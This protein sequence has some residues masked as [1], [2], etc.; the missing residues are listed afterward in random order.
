MVQRN[1]TLDHEFICITENP[2]NL[3]PGIK[4]MDLELKAGIE[5]WWYKPMI[6]NPHL[7]LQGTILFLDLDMIIF[8]NM[9][10]LFSY[11]QGEFC[12]IRDF[13]RHII[14]NYDKFNSSIMRFET[15]Q[16]SQVYHK[17]M[18]DMQG[19][20]RRFQGDQDWTRHAIQ[21]DYNYWPDEWIQ[22]YKWEM[23]GKPRMT[24]GPRG[25]RD[26][27]SQGEPDILPET[28]IAVFHGDPN[29]HYCKDEWVQ[30]NWC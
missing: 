25:T 7:G 19:I 6:F 11:K 10:K 23:R 28:F 12:I 15:G 2:T 4:I 16:H 22:S 5:G 20:S 30:K 9:D 18:E 13:N 14:P 3:D 24:S 27:E 26:F 8:G 1:L 21:N 29:P 17:Y